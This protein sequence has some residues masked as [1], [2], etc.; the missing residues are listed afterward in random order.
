[1]EE[2]NFS[3][4]GYWSRLQANW[5]YNHVKQVF[6]KIYLQLFKNSEFNKCSDADK[7][8][9]ALLKITGGR[10]VPRVFIHGK[11][12][13]GGDETAA[14]CKNGTFKKKVEAGPWLH[15]NLSENHESE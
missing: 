12:F 11:F 9:D 10:S 3:I 8:Q 1:L 4:E 6:L 13:G 5:A 15:Y 2:S 7:I 14:A